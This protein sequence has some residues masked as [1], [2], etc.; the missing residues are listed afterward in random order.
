MNRLISRAQR[1]AVD[2]GRTQPG[3]GEGAARTVNS[4]P[5]R[6][7]DPGSRFFHP[8][9]DQIHVSLMRANVSNIVWKNIRA[10][11]TGRTQPDEWR[12]SYRF[13][14]QAGLACWQT[15]EF[16]RGRA[17]PR[18]SCDRHP[19]E[20]NQLNGISKRQGRDS[21]GRGRP[22]TGR[23]ARRA[24]RNGSLGRRHVPSAVG[25]G[26]RAQRPGGQ[27]REGLVVVGRSHTQRS[28]RLDPAPPQAIYETG[29]S[30]APAARDTAAT[31]SK[32]RRDRG[33]K[34][35]WR[36]WLT[37]SATRPAAVTR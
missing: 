30:V 13:R 11:G 26:R 32:T 37:T 7:R 12:E 28:Q 16:K 35:C 1:G 6:W 15:L 33:E 24:A 27:L 4:R 29:P 21:A 31:S 17:R 14:A 3:G 18:A 20:R 5:R 36:R 19:A 22:A 34:E 8:L 10:S 9:R 2:S 25:H 23:E